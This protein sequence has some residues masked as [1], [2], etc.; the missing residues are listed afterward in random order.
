MN[1][2]YT[3]MGEHTFQISADSSNLMSLFKKSFQSFTVVPD[4]SVDM[5]V[6]IKGGYGTPL[7]TFDV[8]ITNKNSKLIFQRDDYLIEAD[9]D[10]RHA[11]LSVYNGMALKHAFI[12]LYSSFIVY[13]NWGLLIHSSCVIENGK[14]YLFSD[15]SGTVKSAVT[16][17][18]QRALSDEA[19]L[20]K[21]TP[22]S[23]A[24][25]HSPFRYNPDLPQGERACPLESIQIMYQSFQNKRSRLEKT[26]GLLRLMDKVFYWTY[27]PRETKRI[28]S[29]LKLLTNKVPVYD[30]YLQK[31]QTIQEMIS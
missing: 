1:N 7:V 28:L 8:N 29:L 26:H 5:V 20:I 10:Y 2:I 25:F 16:S 24:V 17:H 12:N 18:P 4:T 23:T 3:R 22:D 14:A 30:L 15:Q 11:V 21:I 9:P 19:T 13:H 31:N 27:N 6:H